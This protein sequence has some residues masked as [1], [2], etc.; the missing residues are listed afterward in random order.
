MTSHSTQVKVPWEV[1]LAPQTISQVF[2]LAQIPEDGDNSGLRV[3]DFGCGN[4]RYLQMFSMRVP[5]SRVCGVEA[6]PARVEEVLGQGL[7]CLQLDRDR[8]VLPFVGDCFDVVFSSN[9]IEHIPRPLY[10]QHL[11]EIHRVLKPGGRFVVGTPNYPIKR[12]YDLFTAVRS[13][14]TWYFLFDDPTHCNRLSVRRLERDL[15]QHF[16]ELRLMP[17]YLFLERRIPW[18]RRPSVRHRL[19]IFGYKIVG[20]CLK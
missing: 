9:V 3:L 12:L 7:Q 10:L 15:R 4:G 1:P 2:E 20:R 11:A 19:R 6:D 16:K 18:L 8:G 5:R 13:K 17:T 14:F